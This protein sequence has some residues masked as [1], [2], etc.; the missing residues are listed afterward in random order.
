MV[1]AVVLIRA[2]PGDVPALA[3]RIAGIGGVTEVYSVSGEWDLIAV[4]RV[5]EYERIA[6]IVT[7]EIAQVSGIERTNTLTA[8]RVYSKQDLE[9]AWDMFD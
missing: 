2:V 7:E 8:F 5:K 1:A 6:E 9:R 3:R 4:L